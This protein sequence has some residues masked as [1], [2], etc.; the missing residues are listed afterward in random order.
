[1]RSSGIGGQ[2]V[3]E[4][5]MMKNKDKYAVVVRKPNNEI[6]IDKQEYHSIS[7][8][9][10]FLKLPILRVIVAFVESL[11]VGMKTLTF[12]AGFYE[13]EEAEKT[14][15]LEKAAS[16]LFKDS[17]E[18][19][20]MGLTVILAML[21]AIGIFMVLPWFVT[22]KLATMI[23]EPWL[24][25]LIE[26]VLRLG[27]FII[28][29]FCI[30]LTKDIRRVYMYHGA[31]HKTIN[32]VENGL[33]LTIENV[34]KQS[35]EHRRCGTSFMLYVMIISIIFFMFIRVDNL[36]LRILFRI[37]LVPVIAGV[38]YEFIRFTGKYDNLFTKILSR[39][40]MWMQALTTREPGVD[41]IEIAIWSVE[42][43]FDWK[44]YI[45]EME[46]EKKTKGSK[47]SKKS[48]KS[49]NHKKNKRELAPEVTIEQEDE[50]EKKSKEESV[51]KIAPAVVTKVAPLKR[52]DAT[53][54]R[55]GFFRDIPKP[56]KDEPD[57]EAAM[58][59]IIQEKEKEK[60]QKSKN[61]E[62]HNK[63]AVIKKADRVRRPMPPV[64]ELHR[65]SIL[66]DAEKEDDDDEILSA[67]DKFF[68]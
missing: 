13:E 55:G 11:S 15:K 68:E 14:D 36:A 37:L 57:A 51:P 44:A 32:C 24:Q 27:I 41:M 35:K 38:S 40:G 23:K 49:E 42:A 67:L 48:K 21:L 5:V 7:E 9:Y 53:T 46:K 30:S 62:V 33:E 54:R 47:N 6:V 45:A 52:A 18:S 2:A 16:A 66:E 10:K 65:D 1:M 17:A 20:V 22:E 39:P 64:E 50:N 43:V 3:I 19:V 60:P 61:H 12:S 28:Y 25:A 63:V 58:K 56:V 31:E 59:E 34:S 29:V 4:G 26:G 8:K